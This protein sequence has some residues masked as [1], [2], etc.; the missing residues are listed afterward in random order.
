[1]YTA[2]AGNDLGIGTTYHRD[3]AVQVGTHHP[4]T[5]LG[6]RIKDMSAGVSVTVVCPDTDDRHPRPH[7]GQELIS[8][9]AR[10]MH[11]AVTT[12]GF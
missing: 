2:S 8:I 12:F 1:M 4:G 3:V 10:A 9:E 7:R 11:R 6:Q 5:G